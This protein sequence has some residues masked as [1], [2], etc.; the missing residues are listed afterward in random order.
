M[1][2]DYIFIREPS[3]HDAL[4]QHR[5]AKVV[6]PAL[7]LVGVVLLLAV[8]GAAAWCLGGTVTRSINIS[9]V[10]FPQFGI[11]Q[12][13]SQVDGFVSY[14]NAEV[15]D[16]VEYGDLIAIVPQ[17]ELLE[18][19]RAAQTA[20]ESA[21]EGPGE[22]G[23]EIGAGAPAEEA[24]EGEL[25]A[26]YDSYQCASMIHTPVYGRVVEMVRV[27]QLIHAG[28]LVAS[29]TNSDL[30]SNMA[31][32]RAYVPM[33]VARSI[34][35]GMEVRVYPQF[36]S[37]GGYGYIQGLVSD[38][39]SYPITQTDIS[40]QL[41]RFYPSENVPQEENIIEVRV[42]MTAGSGMD[43]LSW[44]GAEGGLSIDIGTLCSMEVVVSEMTPWESLWS[45]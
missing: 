14:V 2:T 32:I 43:S 8:S 23:G 29:V 30:S 44:S 15:G 17:T 20:G 35:K 28:D 1:D 45:K 24:P 33:T 7:W 22:D 16:I 13:T 37:D 3:K 5:Q 6:S 19:I 21:A 25:A 10:V 26:L 34:R 38:I 39:S 27:G 40:E 9:G 42:T 36:S 41:G 12:V 11:R 18:E 31:E 4:T